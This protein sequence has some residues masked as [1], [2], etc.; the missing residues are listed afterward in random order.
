MNRYRALT[1]SA[2]LFALGILAIPAFGAEQEDPEL[3]AAVARFPSIGRDGSDKPVAI[4]N[5]HNV[6]RAAY[7]ISLAGQNLEGNPNRSAAFVL[8][9]LIDEELLFQEATRQGL[10]PTTAELDRAIVEARARLTP[11]GEKQLLALAAQVSGFQG[12][13]NEYF[14]SK[15]FREAYGRMMA[16]GKLIDSASMGSTDE[17]HAAAKVATMVESLKKRAAIERK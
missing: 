13:V 1:G 4:V 6:S 9:S 11:E 10:S 8:E 15:D 5:G 17:K 7:E 3:A 14:E 2:L 16:R 12:T